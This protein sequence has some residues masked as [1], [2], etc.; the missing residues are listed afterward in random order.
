MTSEIAGEGISPCHSS[1][2][3][4]HSL[5][6]QEVFTPSTAPNNSASTDVHRRWFDQMSRVKSAGE[7]P[8]AERLQQSLRDEQNQLMEAGVVDYCLVLG[9]LFELY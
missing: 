1:P 4:Q 5:T 8:G 9:A 6:H 7:S 3:R 2:K